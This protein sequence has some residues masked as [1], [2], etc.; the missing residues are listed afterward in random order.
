[1]KLRVAMAK[2]V[3]CVSQFVK[4]S[5]IRCNLKGEKLEVRYVG[6]ESVASSRTRQDVRAEFGLG[7]DDIVIA[8]IGFHG[9]LKGNDVLFEAIKRLAV[10]YPKLRLLQIGGERS[11]GQ[12]EG[13]KD[14]SEELGIA[15]H[16]VWT[17]RRSDVR[18]ILI[19]G[20]VYCQPSRS[21]GLP[22]AV[23]EGMDAGL[24]V[25]ASDVGGIPEVITDGLNGL[26]VP[27]DRPDLLAEKLDGLLSE[28]SIGRA[29]VQAGKELVQTKFNLESQT[30]KLV[31]MYE[32]ILPEST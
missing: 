25:V 8:T 12:T 5:Y 4:D 20:D 6:V 19:A 7:D 10:K 17:G 26:L 13:L 28:E 27:P 9:A 30:A 32:E 14:L 18:D 3:F 15:D 31:D 16:I 11:A 1:M 2:R 21:E 24:P 23:L 22:S 29:M